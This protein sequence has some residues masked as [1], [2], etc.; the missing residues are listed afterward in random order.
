[1]LESIKCEESKKLVSIVLDVTALYLMEFN[2]FNIDKN[3]KL[4]LIPI[5]IKLF[6]DTENSF[7]KFY[8][9][10]FVKK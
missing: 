9:N 5:M 10:K 7:N 6:I 1:M 4:C 8:L 2:Y 3:T